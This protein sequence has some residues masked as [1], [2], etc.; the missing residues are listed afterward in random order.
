LAVSLRGR[1]EAFLHPSALPERLAGGILARLQRLE[2]DATRHEIVLK[3]S[4]DQISRHLKRVA[5][6]EQRSQNGDDPAQTDLTK[7]LLAY[8]LGRAG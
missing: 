3:E 8:K 4:A 2:D 7:Q 6:I 1:I 5:A